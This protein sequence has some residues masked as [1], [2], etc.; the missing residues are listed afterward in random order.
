MP[1][2]KTKALVRDIQPDHFPKRRSVLA[3]HLP[4]PRQTRHALQ[5]L[6]L[7]HRV[8]LVLVGNAGPR[9]DDAHVAFQ[10]V[11]NLGKLIQPRGPEHPS[12]GDKPDVPTRVELL[13]R[14]V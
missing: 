4:Q 8:L 9:A 3:G 12:T 5:P 7:F 6:P 11:Q 1:R 2:K 14:L 13:H 10:H